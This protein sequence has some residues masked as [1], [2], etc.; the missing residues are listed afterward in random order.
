MRLDVIAT[1]KRVGIAPIQLRWILDGKIT[2]RADIAQKLQVVM[3]KPSDEGL[4]VVP[5]EQHVQKDVDSVTTE[6]PKTWTCVFIEDIYDL[7]DRLNLEG[8]DGLVRLL[9]RTAVATSEMAAALE[10]ET[11]VPALEWMFTKAAKNPVFLRPAP[12]WGDWLPKPVLTSPLAVKLW[13]CH[14]AI[15]YRARNAG[16]NPVLLAHA[17]YRRLGIRSE[18]LAVRLEK[19]SGVSFVEWLRN[20]SSRHPAFIGEPRP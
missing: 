4:P 20:K 10:W 2:P 1:A 12:A 18:T 8:V 13:G 7:A 9:D 17:I 5:S 14:N 15:D 16:T 11:G 3:G 6:R 19:V